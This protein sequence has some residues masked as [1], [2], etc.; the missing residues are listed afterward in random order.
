MMLAKFKKAV[1]AT[2]FAGAISNAVIA[3]V[4]SEIDKIDFKMEIE[5]E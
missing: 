1:L 5:E 4:N 2:K 3:W